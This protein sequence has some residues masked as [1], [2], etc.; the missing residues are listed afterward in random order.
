MVGGPEQ[1]AADPPGGSTSTNTPNVID[2]DST[3]RPE[4][5]DLAR[6]LLILAFWLPWVLCTYLAFTPG[7]PEALFRVSDILL[8]GFAFS[9]LTFALGLA[10]RRK[11]RL[12]AAAWMV[13]YGAAIE[14]VQYFELGR[15]AEL[16]DLLVDVAGIG[17][18]AVAL[19]L[20]A[21]RAESLARLIGGAIT[22]WF[23]F[24]A[25]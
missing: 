20:F 1:M 21:A 12:W 25:K 6:A 4:S 5:F 17:V 16:K 19:Q 11:D 13:A 9:Y 3:P 14:L 10:H 7:P 23:P 22:R 18:G 24:V 2:V 15:S 8:H